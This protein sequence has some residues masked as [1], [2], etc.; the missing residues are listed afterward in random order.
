M[1]TYFHANG[2][3]LRLRVNIA[4]VVEDPVIGLVTIERHAVFAS[5]VATIDFLEEI[6]PWIVTECRVV[7][8]VPVVIVERSEVVILLER[9]VTMRWVI[10]EGRGDGV[11]FR[12]FRVQ[13]ASGVS[14]TV[15]IL[16]VAH[17]VLALCD[18]KFIVGRTGGLVDFGG[19][20]VGERAR[21]K[22]VAVVSVTRSRK[23]ELLVW[24]D[25]RHPQGSAIH[26]AD[27]RFFGDD[28]G[29]FVYGAV[30]PE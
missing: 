24:A 12:K 5:A 11:P 15:E 27:T 22:V 23:F 7:V 20:V 18:G 19:A 14:R 4:F 10:I 30:V 17:G 9:Y 16:P 25:A 8:A 13:V 28:I 3:S 21:P 29:A 1:S 2:L 6:I 26:Y